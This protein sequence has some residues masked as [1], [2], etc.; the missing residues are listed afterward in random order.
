MSKILS[1]RIENLLKH[2]TVQVESYGDKKEVVK[3][4][5]QG[6]ILWNF[7]LNSLLLE[8]RS[9]GFYVQAYADDLAVLIADADMLW[10][11]GMTQKAINTAANWAS[12]QELQLS[13]RKT[14]I[15]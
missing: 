6:S 14:E 12:K 1:S 11:R 10:I 9:K 4:N 2:R 8:L 5:L 7:A 15:M 13:C 3:E